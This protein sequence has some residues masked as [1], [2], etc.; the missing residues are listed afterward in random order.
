M[1][2]KGVRNR[3]DAMLELHSQGRVALDVDA[4]DALGGIRDN[5]RYLATR[6]DQDLSRGAGRWLSSSPGTGPSPVNSTTSGPPAGRGPGH[7]AWPDT[8][9]CRGCLPGHRPHPHG[10]P[11]VP[12]NAIPAWHRADRERP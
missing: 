4:A 7:C 3:R 5:T 8:W 2:I 9:C 11:R 12:G 1:A 10:A 6:N